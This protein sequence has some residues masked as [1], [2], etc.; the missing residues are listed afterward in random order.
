MK[1]IFQQKIR[2]VFGNSDYVQFCDFQIKLMKI[3]L[4]A[5]SICLI[6]CCLVNNSNGIRIYRYL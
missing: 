3:L 1:H 6:S 4:S 2:N 5:E